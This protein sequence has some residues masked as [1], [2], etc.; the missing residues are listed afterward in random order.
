MGSAAYGFPEHG[1]GL[2]RD[3]P[4]GVD[5][6]C[7]SCLR[8][9][10]FS[11]LLGLDHPFAESGDHNVISL[12]EVILDDLKNAFDDADTFFLGNAEFFVHGIDNVNLRQAHDGS[13][14]IIKKAVFLFPSPEPIRLWSSLYPHYRACAIDNPDGRPEQTEHL[15]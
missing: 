7:L 11:L 4:P 10:P 13:S 9:P 2:E 12:V 6:Q 14:L 15:P 5:H 1:R 3:N 8:I